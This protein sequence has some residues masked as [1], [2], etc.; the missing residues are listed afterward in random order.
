MATKEK[1]IKPKKAPAKVAAAKKVAAPKKVVAAKTVKAPAVEK[2]EPEVAKE[3]PKSN[4]KNA[5]FN[6]F[7]LSIDKQ[8]IIEKFS[9]KS[10]D[11]GSPE[12]QVALASHKIVH[13]AKHLDENPKD[14]H[15]RRGLLKVISKRR[16]ILHYLASK[17]APRYGLLIQSLGLVK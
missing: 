2:T 14:N 13:L 12:V 4:R 16:R 3:A 6:D 9:L 10:G 7:L 5:Q 1:T 15:S 11:T 8:G 17:D